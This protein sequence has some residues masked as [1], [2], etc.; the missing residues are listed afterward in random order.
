MITGPK[1]KLFYVF[2]DLHLN[3]LSSWEEFEV[4]GFR[5]LSWWFLVV[6]L[7]FQIKPILVSNVLARLSHV[8]DE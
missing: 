5:V 2:G 4:A 8:V 6:H 7:F 3:H 1:P